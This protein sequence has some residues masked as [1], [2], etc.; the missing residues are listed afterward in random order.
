MNIVLLH[1]HATGRMLSP[2]GRPVE[3][4]HLLAFAREATVFRKAFSMSSVASP[5][6]AAL[7]CGQLPH[8]V[9]MLGPR[10]RGFSLTH[11]NSHLAVVLAKQGFLTVQVGAQALFGKADNRPYARVLGDEAD[12]AGQ[13]A[14][15]RDNDTAQ[16]ACSFLREH[17][18]VAAASPFFLECG[19]S[20]AQRPFS[21][22]APG[23]HGQFCLPADGLPDTPR[24][25]ADFSAY[26]HQLAFMDGCVGQVLDTLRETGRMAD[27]AIIFTTDHG[28][29][30]PFAQG[31][32]TDAGLG[33]ALMIHYPKNPSAGL[34]SEAMVSHLDI[35]P[36]VCDWIGIAAPQWLLGKSLLPVFERRRN[37][38][39]DALLGQT[40]Y[41]AAYEPLRSIRTVRHK[42]VKSYDPD[43]RPVAPNIPDSPS[44]DV[45]YEAGWALYERPMLALYNLVLD[46]AEQHNL[47]D[48]SELWPVRT[49]LL[50]RMEGT[51]RELGDPLMKGFVLPPPNGLFNRRSQRSA[52]DAVAAEQ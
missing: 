9:G 5:A 41:A 20:L 23:T 43:R 15:D 26:R 24:T 4:P 42:L 46:P 35:F 22:P 50:A 45:L 34:V 29:P 44:K 6:Q 52:S 19:F 27:T 33:V 10:A 38:I 17:A 39:H 25:R 18:K 51:L 37:E 1:T 40:T 7:F 48:V 30:F 13:G 8:L 31:Q 12:Q 32:L 36:T 28:A 47:I 16:A 2:Y 11:P 14:L 3:T 49:D 21:A